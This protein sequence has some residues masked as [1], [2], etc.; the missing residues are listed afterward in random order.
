MCSKVK[1]YS[2]RI[3]ATPVLRMNKCLQDHLRQRHKMTLD[4][5][6]QRCGGVQ[7]ALEETDDE[8]KVNALVLKGLKCTRC[9]AVTYG[10]HNMCAHWTKCHGL[11]HKLP[12]VLYEARGAL[13]MATCG[14]CPSRTIFEGTLPLHNRYYHG[15]EVPDVDIG[16]EDHT[17]KNSKGWTTSPVLQTPQAKESSSSNLRDL[18]LECPACQLR[19]RSPYE[20]RQH[21]LRAHSAHS[22]MEGGVDAVLER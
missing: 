8:R 11:L 18:T 13:G 4:K 22:I 2:C 5:Y 12:K 20:A 14:K 19:F 16:A 1:L 17:E 21:I 9:P 6:I 3:C 7:R 10:A 15:V